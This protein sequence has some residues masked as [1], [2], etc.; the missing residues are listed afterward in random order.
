MV[1]LRASTNNR[2]STVLDVFLDAIEKWGL[3]SHVRGD[4]GGE[5]KMVSVFMIMLR[6]LHRA[7]FMW[8]S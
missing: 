6:G 4:R 1:A 3:P 2:A 5:N 8:G 7:S